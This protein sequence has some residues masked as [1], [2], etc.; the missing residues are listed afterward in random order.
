VHSFWGASRCWD[1]VYA[2]IDEFGSGNQNDENRN[3]IFISDGRDTSS[4][5][6]RE[7]VIENARDR[8]VRVN[9]IGF[10]QDADAGTL[11]AITG[12]TDGQYYS[13]LAIQDI[14][15]GFLQVVDDFAGQYMLRWATLSRTDVSFKPS[16]HIAIGQ[17]VAA[18]ASTS[19]FEVEQYAGDELSGVLRVAPSRSGDKST[20]FLRAVYVPRYIWKLKFYVESPYPFTVEKV[21]ADDGGLCVAWNESVTTDPIRGGKWIYLESPAVGNIGSPLP[22]AAFGPILRFDF[23]QVF[24]DDVTPF[25]FLYVDNTLYDAV[26]SFAIQDWNNILP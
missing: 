5:H 21:G 14:G 1:A 26:Q 4:I 15:D 18:Y 19:L 3:V 17:T 25:D 20:Y 22:F 23:G 7:D 16:F 2:A 13:A 10:G 9:A 12:Q 6:T 11:Q 8:G 24:D